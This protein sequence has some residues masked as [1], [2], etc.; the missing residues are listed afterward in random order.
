M[1]NIITKFANARKGFLNEPAD[2]GLIAKFKERFNNSEELNEFLEIYHVFDGEKDWGVLFPDWSICNLAYIIELMD[3]FIDAW[4]EDE[5]FFHPMF[6]FIPFISTTSKTD[7]G[8]LVNTDT[9]YNGCVLEYDCESGEFIIWSKSLKAFIEALFSLSLEK[10]PV[11][12]SPE[13]ENH[14]FLSAEEVSYYSHDF[15]EQDIAFLAQW[16]EFVF[17]VVKDERYDVFDSF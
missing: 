12:L 2:S 11:M 5:K 4:E 1:K 15:T 10:M 17:P 16:P 13:D 3:I 14:P 9:K 8:L 7:I 6:F